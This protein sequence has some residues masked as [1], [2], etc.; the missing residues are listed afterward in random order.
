MTAPASRPSSKK[1]APPA[2]SP[3]S[4][5]RP[6]TTILN[7]F[8]PAQSILPKPLASRASSSGSTSN[9][10]KP[11]PSL[12]P[13]SAASGIRRTSTMKSV[14]PNPQ[15]AVVVH[16]GNGKP[17][18]APSTTTAPTPSDFAKNFTGP[19]LDDLQVWWSLDNAD[20]QERERRNVFSACTPV[21]TPDTAGQYFGQLLPMIEIAELVLIHEFFVRHPDVVDLS[22]FTD[23]DLTLGVLFDILY[24]NTRY[25]TIGARVHAALL[26]Y[27]LA[28]DRKEADDPNAENG[29]AT[30][31]S[32]D[33]RAV[34]PDM[35]LAVYN[36][37]RAKLDPYAFIYNSDPYNLPIDVRIQLLAHLVNLVVATPRF[38]NYIHDQEDAIA[39]LNKDKLQ[40]SRDRKQYEADL[41]QLKEQA[42]PLEQDLQRIEQEI[43]AI[44]SSMGWAPSTAAQPAQ[45]DDSGNPPDAPPTSTG[46]DKGASV[47][48]SATRETR[49]QFAKLSHQERTARH[50]L[51]A[52]N[53]KIRR[54]EKLLAQVS[55]ANY[56]FDGFAEARDRQ[57]DKIRGGEILRSHRSNPLAGASITMTMPVLYAIPE[58]VDGVVF[59]GYDRYFRL[60]WFWRCLGGLVIERGPFIP[61]MVDRLRQTTAHKTRSNTTMYWTVCDKG[62]LKRLIDALLERGERESEL[63]T[64]IRAYRKAIEQS[65]PRLETFMTERRKL[66]ETMN[67]AT[68]SGVYVTFAFHSS[69]SPERNAAAVPALL[70]EHVARARDELM[71]F[72][73]ALDKWGALVFPRL[74]PSGDAWPTIMTDSVERQL[75]LTSNVAD[76]R[77]LAKQLL[78]QAHSHEVLSTY[79]VSYRTS[80]PDLT[81]E[82]PL[83][84]CSLRSF[85]D[86][87]TCSSLLLWCEQAKRELPQFIQ[88]EEKYW[89]IRHRQQENRKAAEAEAAEAAAAATLKRELAHSEQG[90]DSSNTRSRRA[91]SAA[92]EAVS[93]LLGKVM[94]IPKPKRESTAPKS[95]NSPKAAAASTDDD[96]ASDGYAPPVG[97]RKRGVSESSDRNLRQ[98]KRRMEVQQDVLEIETDTSDSSDGQD[99]P[100]VSTRKLRSQRRSQ[101]KEHSPSPKQSRQLRSRAS[102]RETVEIMD[103]SDDAR[104]L[105]AK[106][107]QPHEDEDDDETCDEGEEEGNSSVT[108]NG[109]TLRKRA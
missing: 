67:Q 11:A 77:D 53:S 89:E 36:N 28:G 32:T 54:L 81:A 8:T 50:S 108:I 1:S 103:S 16:S 76:L 71:S 58:R 62:E 27:L 13:S 80:F 86:C 26:S 102:R 41:A 87:W 105:H 20:P 52:V 55:G 35:W 91:K 83:D 74:T 69:V 59:L 109:R 31:T 5:L 23:D 22:L 34:D 56:S 94:P 82:S 38:A 25:L 104:P 7:Y 14:P 45:D 29:K 10:S 17:A 88:A 79:R 4:S 65:L 24:E 96:D 95:K 21:V 12:P 49:S 84:Q 48:R 106:H 100:L 101:P 40:A 37:I 19:K 51:N 33:T 72:F 47:A 99:V 3:S 60:Y 61:E 30:A 42:K 85:S 92:V 44:R 15:I 57:V 39:G 63:L 9:N 107:T 70:K 73:E 6:R 46:D 98:A 18:A 43:E 78:E 2:A 97:V 75:S 93:E 64:N 68:R 66:A 90:D